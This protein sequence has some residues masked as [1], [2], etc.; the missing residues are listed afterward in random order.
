[1]AKFWN[2]KN[3]EN[4]ELYIEGE[5]VPDNDVWFYEWIGEK[6]SS[7]NA[8]KEELSKY[9][10]KEIT[11]W[12]DSN[13]GDVFAAAGMYIAL[14]ERKGGNIMKIQNA[15]SAATIPAM[16]GKVYIAP[17]GMM[18]IHD[19]LVGLVG[20]FNTSELKKYMGVLDEVKEVI[21]NSYQAKSGRS[22]NKIWQLMKD[23]TYMSAK[24]AIK[25][26]FADEI[27]YADKSKEQSIKRFTQMEKN[28]DNPKDVSIE[29]PPDENTE[30]ITKIAIAKMDLE[31]AL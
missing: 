12:I 8:F 26:G 3:D 31:L 14:M 4:I 16:A 25:E 2:F 27:L 20:Y 13:G 11:V 6:V 18:M 17:V 9:D 1:M 28:K 30:N 23:E 24:T 19:P 10:G 21:I 15:M 29:A 5:I 22:R 7:P